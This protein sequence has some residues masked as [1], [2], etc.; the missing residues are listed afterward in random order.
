AARTYA[1]Q[2]QPGM[3]QQVMAGI[4]HEGKVRHRQPAVG[5]LVIVAERGAGEVTAP[6]HQ[7]NCLHDV[8]LYVVIPW[9]RDTSRPAPDGAR[10]AGSARSCSRPAGSRGC[11]T[12]NR[13]P[14]RLAR[15]SV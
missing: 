9:R 11:A 5:G 15:A 6:A 1:I 14:R 8:V 2:V 12:D 4:A 7:G 10:P 13:T 3:I